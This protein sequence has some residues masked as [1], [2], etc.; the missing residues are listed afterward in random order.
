MGNV[1]ILPLWAAAPILFVLLTLAITLILDLDRPRT[2]SI[3]V[4]QAPLLDLKASLMP[5]P[6]ITAAP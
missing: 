6:A 1:D 2:G 3:L 4:S 5:R